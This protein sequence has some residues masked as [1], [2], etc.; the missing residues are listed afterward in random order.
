MLGLGEEFYKISIGDMYITY[1]V[2]VLI[3][4]LGRMSTDS[5]ALEDYS[6]VRIP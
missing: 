1:D 2:K 5:I 6:V 3:F 4:L